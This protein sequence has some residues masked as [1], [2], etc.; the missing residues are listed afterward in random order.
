MDPAVRYRKYAM[1]SSFIRLA[2][3]NQNSMI[4]KEEYLKEMQEAHY[5][6]K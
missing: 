6:Q 5:M 1:G 3:A 4:M 2:V